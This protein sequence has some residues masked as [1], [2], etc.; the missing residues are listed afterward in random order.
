MRRI[1]QTS[2]KK[3]NC[4]EGENTRAVFDFDARMKREEFHFSDDTST[5][6]RRR[7]L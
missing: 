1:T 4:V 3:S 2:G 5:L 6:L 7:R